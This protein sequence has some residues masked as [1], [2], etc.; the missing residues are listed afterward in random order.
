MI[1]IAAGSSLPFCGHDSQQIVSSA[2]SVLAVLGRVLKVSPLYRSPAWP[3]RSDPEFINGI[4]LIETGLTPQ[5]L[6]A[7]LHAIEAGY[8]RRRGKKNAPRTLDLDL[9]AYHQHCVKSTA[10]GE[11]D[12]PHPGLASRD[13]VLAPLS[14]IAPDWRH[15][16]DGRTA[17]Q[18]LEALTDRPARRIS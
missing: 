18:L 13:F 6:L 4:A 5:A 9:I 11:P 15:P 10:P 12:L 3:D 14:D 1:L 17:K 8:G 16:A 7:G 2:L